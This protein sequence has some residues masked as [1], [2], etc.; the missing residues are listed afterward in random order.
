MIANWL[1]TPK[2]VTYNTVVISYSGI[3]FFI[4]GPVMLSKSVQLDDM[5]RQQQ[6]FIN[7]F[8]YINNNYYAT[9]AYVYTILDVESAPSTRMVCVPNASPKVVF[10]SSWSFS[11]ILIKAITYFKTG[12]R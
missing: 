2:K 8:H 11:T 3:K 10:D 9:L 1:A 4:R 5:T 12:S 7:Q 6:I